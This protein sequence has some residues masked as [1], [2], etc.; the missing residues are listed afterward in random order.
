MHRNLVNENVVR[1][2][3]CF[4]DEENVYIILE[5]CS[6]RVTNLLR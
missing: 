6:K 4:E 2:F 1:F 3:H 5:N